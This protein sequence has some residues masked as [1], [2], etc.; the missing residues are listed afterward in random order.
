MGKFRNQHPSG[1]LMTEWTKLEKCAVCGR[2]PSVLPAKNLDRIVICFHDGK[3]PMGEQPAY[4]S[5]EEW[6]MA[7]IDL[8][9]DH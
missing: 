1:E 4:E 9:S 6:N 8:K 2:F 3:F 5:T 7:Q